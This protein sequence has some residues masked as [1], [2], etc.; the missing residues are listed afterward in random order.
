MDAPIQIKNLD[1]KTGVKKKKPV[2]I[3]LPNIPFSWI[4]IGPSG[5]GK[6]NM[7]LNVLEFYKKHFK[8]HHI[9]L[10]SPSLGLDP[11]TSEIKAGWKYADFNP[12]IIESVIEQQKKIM[13]EKPKKVPEILIIMDDCIAEPGAF[14]HKGVLEKLFYRCRHFHCSL[15]ITSQKYSSL[16]RGIRL[17]S[18]TVSF[19]KPYNESEKEHILKEHSDK[20][21]KDNMAKMLEYIWSHPYHFAHFDYTKNDS[22]KKYQCCLHN[23]LNLKS[24]GGSNI[25]VDHDEHT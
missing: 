10:F 11:K 7:L 4:L 9:I 16:S 25:D 12:A 20:Y 8:E 23:F 19:F 2:N 13:K 18:K 21:S 24:F 14:N 17:N 1:K 22:D 3:H 15:L 6:S 5:T